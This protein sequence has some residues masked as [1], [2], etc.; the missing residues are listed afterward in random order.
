MSIYVNE[1]PLL[2]N[3]EALIR[4]GALIKKISLKGGPSFKRGHSF[5][6]IRYT[7]K[8]FFQCFLQDVTVFLPL[9]QDPT[10][11]MAEE[12]SH[13]LPPSFFVVHLSL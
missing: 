7:E 11:G 3:G 13:D 6:Q 5:E 8:T 1:R 9:D 2:G 10:T 12:G 4:E